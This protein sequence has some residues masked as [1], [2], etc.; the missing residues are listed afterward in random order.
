M[1]S[2]DKKVYPTAY[3]VLNK[4]PVPSRD[5]K[6]TPAVPPLLAAITAVHSDQRPIRAAIGDPA[7]AGKRPR[8]LALRFT[9]AAQEGTS[10]RF[11]CVWVSVNAHTFLSVS[12]ELLSSVTAVERIIRE[13]G[14]P[15]K[16]D[17]SGFDCRGYR[18]PVPYVETFDRKGQQRQ[19]DDAETDQMALSEGLPEE[20][21]PGDELH[22]R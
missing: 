21:D 4:K 17:T 1:V 19:P 20:V 14:R 3:A 15:V 12:S 6:R 22:R 13:N 10:L 8:L 5:G 16:G 9:W 18:L 7:N 11:C 2:S